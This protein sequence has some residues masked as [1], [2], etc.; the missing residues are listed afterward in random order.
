MAKIGRN[1]PCPCGSGRKYKHCCGD[2]LK[3]QR[4]GGA[5]RLDALPPEIKLALTRH[6]AQEMIRT[7]QQGL[8]RPIIAEKVGEHQVVR[9][10]DT[11]HYSKEWKFFP[12]F[13]S[14][15]IKDVLGSDWGNAEIAKPIEERHP[16]MQWYDAYCHFQKAIEKRP[17]GTYAVNATGVIYCYIGLAYNLYLLKHNVKLQERFVA[18]LKNREQ[19]QGAYYELVVANCLIRAGFDLALEDET[20]EASKHC[21][22]SAISKQTDKKYWVEAKMRSVSGLLGKT[23]VDGGT[24]TSKPTSQLSKHLNQA[25]KKPADDE[26][27]I[28]IDVNTS[29]LEK[30]DPASGEPEMPTWVDAAERQLDAGEKDR[31]ENQRAY[32]FVTNM[33]FHRALD[34][35]ARGHVAL[36]HGL[37]ISDFPNVGEYR[38][39]ELWRRKQKHID[40]YQV[41]EA[42]FSYPKIPNTFDGSLS[43]PKSDAENR[44]EIGQTYFF[45]DVGENG[46]LGEVTA[47]TVLEAEKR[48]C[49]GVTTEDGKNL[50]LSRDM[51]DE[52]LVS[53][54]EHPDAY[55]GVVQQASKKLTNVYELFEWLV[56]CQKE[57]P[58]EKLLAQCKNHLDVEALAKL[59]H[60]ELV[61]EVCERQ[62][63]ASAASDKSLDSGSE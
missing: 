27:M 56:D 40:A 50:I 46:M 4:S 51:T 20:D 53:Y 28:F 14:G 35:E 61:L 32:V 17:D 22:F 26:R 60:M 34:D 29:P 16:I 39:S 47:A 11:L 12:D 15:Y 13:L 19:F 8:G 54:K 41:L 62:A 63:S 24:D 18:R 7:Q 25:L 33:P 42:L 44:I 48:M 43:L 21:E 3:E 55:F 57:T 59:D 9:V 45:E 49:F 52:E 10:G 6:E 23:E 38:L 58:K 37:G 1:A 2:P 30:H 5:Q 36:V 31:K